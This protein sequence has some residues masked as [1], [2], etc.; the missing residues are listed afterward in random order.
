MRYVE[1]DMKMND[2]GDALDAGSALR[3]ARRAAGL[4]QSELAACSG[5]AQA[6]ISEIE[7]GRRQPSI[8]FFDRLLRACGHTITVAGPES[9]EVDP[10][11]LR[12]LRDQAQRPPAERLGRLRQLFGLKGLA[13][14]P[15][16]PP[17]GVMAMIERVDM[18]VIQLD[19]E[20]LL[21]AV[22]DGGVEFIVIGGIAAILRGDIVT[23]E[24]ADIAPRDTRANLQALAQVLASLNSR[25]L[26]AINELQPAAVDMPI[27]GDTLAG[28]T[29]GRFLTEH[30]VLDVALWR[31]DGTSYE[32]W[33]Q[34][35]TPVNLANGARVVVAALDD[36]IASKAEASRP[37]GRYALARL[38]AARDILGDSDQAQRQ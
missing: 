31:A 4:S 11:D 38:C 6:A 17:A 22:V 3:S 9:L 36:L 29:S 27:T 33:A 20:V 28:L 10:H 23:T 26:V 19:P 30:G 13:V 12:L 24:D 2:S 25:L 7:R 5:T 16:A 1:S 35:A 37:T 8:E 15:V 14:P 34:R 21:K 32:Y 18:R